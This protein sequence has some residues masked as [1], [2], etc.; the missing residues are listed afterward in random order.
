LKRIEESA[1]AQSGL[2]SIVIPSSVVVLGKESFAECKSFKSVTF[3]NGSGL[4]WI[5]KSMF[6]E[7]RVNFV[8]LSEQ[9]ARSKAQK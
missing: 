5:N 8:L 3:E 6:R 9:L 4:E 2:Q 7:T 1:F